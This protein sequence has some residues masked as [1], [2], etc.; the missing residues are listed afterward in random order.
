[1]IYMIKLLSHQRLVRL[2]TVGK[3]GFGFKIGMNGTEAVPQ[4]SQPLAA[5]NLASG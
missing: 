4:V 2:K 5:S 3:K 1:M